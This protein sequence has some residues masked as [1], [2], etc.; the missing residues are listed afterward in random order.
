MQQKQFQFGFIGMGNMGYAILMGLLKTWSP[1]QITYSRRAKDEKNEVSARTKVRRS[2]NNAACAASS[3][4]VVLAVKP[5]QM[6]QVVEDIRDVITEDQILISIAAGITIEDLAGRIGRP[7]RIVR[8]MPNTPALVGE[9]M[10]G[11]SYEEAL[12]TEEEKEIIHTV[13]RSFGKMV[14]VE[15]KLINAVVCISGSSPAYVYM[16]IEAL[17]DSG[18]KFGLPR[19]MAYELAAQAVLGSAKMVLETGKHPGELKDQVCSPA[20]TTIAAVSAL[21]EYGLRNAVIK[22]GDACYERCCTLK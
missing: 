14:K 20:G 18:V 19:A 12:F 13:F 8:A 22:A 17:A 11:V 15:E 21:E 6:D 10:T 2:E 16:F 3:R 9:G 7:C 1:D 5:Q 4:F